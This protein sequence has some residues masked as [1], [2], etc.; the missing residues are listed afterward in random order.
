MIAEQYGMKKA[1][2]NNDYDEK[3]EQEKEQQMRKA[4]QDE[5][6]L[7]INKFDQIK[8]EEAAVGD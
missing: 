8:T 2:S 6:L 1:A 7:F 3:A 5:R 4:A